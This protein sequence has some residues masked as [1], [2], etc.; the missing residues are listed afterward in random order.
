VPLPVPLAPDVIVMNEELLTADRAQPAPV[1]TVTL[2]VPP[3]AAKLALVGL[4]EKVHVPPQ[5]VGTLV[6]AVCVVPSLPTA[7]T[8][9]P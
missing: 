5:S 2:P 9:M 4:I 1:V 7:E 3:V 8:P 6:A